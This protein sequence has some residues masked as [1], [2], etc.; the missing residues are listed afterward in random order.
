MIT[1]KL[2]AF[3][4][5]KGS[6]KDTL[7][8]FLSYNSM[9]LFGCRSSI[10]AFAQPLKKIAIDF[11]GLEHQQVFGSIEN[12]NSLTNYL[13]EDLPHYQQMGPTGKMTAREFLQEIGT[14]ICRKMNKNIHIDACFNMIR[15]DKYPLSFITDARF[16]NEIIRVK[17]FG[18]ITIRLTRSID[19]D[20]HISENELDDSN[21]FDI[22]IDNRNMNKSEQENELLKKL[23]SIDWIKD[24]HNLFKV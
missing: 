3:S 2:I 1:Q 19:S 8:G 9:A 4:G 11:F 14:G 7:A 15:R 24:D 16:E 10:Y 18:G 21:I 23:K 20:V 17:E 6:G 22:V 5:K 13:W 12:K